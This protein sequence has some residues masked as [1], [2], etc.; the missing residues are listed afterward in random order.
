[1]PWTPH[2]GDVPARPVGI[3][4][5]ST[6]PRAPP[7]PAARGQM[8]SEGFVASAPAHPPASWPFLPSPQLVL[9]SGPLSD[10]VRPF[11]ILKGSW[12]PHSDPLV[13]LNCCLGSECPSGHALSLGLGFPCLLFFFFWLFL[14]LFIYLAMLGLHCG[15]LGLQLQHVEFSSPNKD[16]T[17]AP[18]LWSTES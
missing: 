6:E 14:F 4:L 10:G 11:S 13:K 12:W 2:A 16:R 8:G 3:C 5:L 1:M 9:S 7:W 17:W 15:M 18:C